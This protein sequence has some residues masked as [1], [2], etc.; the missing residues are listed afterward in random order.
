[1]RDLAHPSKPVPGL[2][3]VRW[4]GVPCAAL[5]MT[6]CAAIHHTPHEPLPSSATRASTTQW[7]PDPLFAYQ[8]EP[9]DSDNRLVKES[10]LYE[11]HHITFPSIGD[12]AQPGDLVAVD[13]HR[14]KL[15]GS[16]PVVI[17]LPIWGRQTYPSNAVTRTLRKR[18]DGRMHVL[19]VLGPEFLIDWPRLAA[20]DDEDEFVDTWIEGADREVTTVIDIRRLIDWAEARPEIDARRTGLIGFSHGAMLAPTIAVQE[21]RITALV[22]V[23]GGAHPHEVIAK[24]VGARTEGVQDHARDT[25]GWSKDEMTDYLEP[26]YGPIDAANYPDRVDPARVLIFDAGRD[27]C[28][29]QSARDALWEAMGRPERYTIDR[30]HRRSFYTMTPLR[31]NWMRHR[32]WRFY[33]EL[34]LESETADPIDPPPPQRPQPQSTPPRETTL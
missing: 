32:I 12:N 24:C 30:K 3:A 18:S 8:V 11:V 10:P 7:Q 17:I 4:I 6:A 23:M 9:I 26:I 20:I 25:F 14:S 22:L 27:E 29:P 31:L 34:L 16:H 19:N 33:R 15:P 21:P 13:Y 5:L 2:S 28:V 1:M